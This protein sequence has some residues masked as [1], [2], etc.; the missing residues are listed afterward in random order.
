MSDFSLELPADFADYEWEVEAKG[1]FSQA[2]INASGKRY[3]LNIYDAARLGQEIE[4]EL[5]RGGIFF[6]PNLVVVKS[7]TR[8]NIE[9]AAAQLARSGVLPTLLAE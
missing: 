5:Q 8:A 4:D 6:E 2:S 9:H 1:W 3:R 7:V